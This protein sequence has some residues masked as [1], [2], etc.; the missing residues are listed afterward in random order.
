MTTII[1][2]LY[3]D[4]A[5]ASAAMAALLDDGQDEDTIQ[6]ITGS[7][8]G[9]AAAAM[10]A[11]RISSVPAA[12]YGEA[13]TGDRALLVVQAPFSPIGTARNAMKVLRKHPAMDVGL[14]DEDEYLRENAGEQYSR[15]ILETHPLLMSN[16][17]R[18]LPHGHIFGNNPIIHSK[19]RTSAIRGGGHMSRFFWPTRLVSAQKQRSSAIR[20]GFLFS[21]LFGLPLLTESWASRKDLPTII[22]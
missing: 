10:K 16:P 18:R 21:S 11:A 17:F 4:P 15:S 6:V 9:G 3:S 22:R 5:A 2:R 19:D 1:T 14:D 12:A 8:A 13:L 7:T 20:G